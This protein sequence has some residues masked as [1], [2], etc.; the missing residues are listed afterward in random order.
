MTDE[1]V[2]DG[3][4]TWVLFDCTHTFGDWTVSKPATETEKGE[5]TRVC[6]GCEKVETQE[7]PM[8]EKPAD[9]PSD[10]EEGGSTVAPDNNPADTPSGGEEGGSTVAPD[11]NPADTP[12]GD[13]EEE[14]KKGCKSTISCV[15]TLGVL[16]IGAVC[17]KARKRKE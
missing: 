11:N 9:A 2:L 15:S 16:A 1:E 12:S 6:S 7:I 14:T 13:K 5:E 3:Y 10:G 8:V 17:I 4:L